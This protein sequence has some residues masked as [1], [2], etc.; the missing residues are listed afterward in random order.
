VADA[1]RRRRTCVGSGERAGTA[2]TRGMLGVPSM[3]V[4]AAGEDGDEVTGQRL[5]G[6]IAGGIVHRRWLVHAGFKNIGFC[7]GEQG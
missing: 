7:V 1:Q 3:G 5:H 6:R 4:A 2:D